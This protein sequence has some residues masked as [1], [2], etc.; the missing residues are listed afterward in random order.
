MELYVYKD[1]YIE[2]INGEVTSCN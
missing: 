1:L 2:N